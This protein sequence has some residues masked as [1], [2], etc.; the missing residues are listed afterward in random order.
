MT[1]TSSNSSVASVSSS[2]VVTA[3][4]VGNATITVRTTDG[5]FTATCA[6]SVVNPVD[7]PEGTYKGSATVLGSSIAIIISIGTQSNGLVAVRLANT[8]AVATSITVSGTSVTIQTTGSY[9]G[10]TFGNITA[11]YSKANNRLSSVKCNGSISSYVSNN[12]SI[13]CTKPTTASYF[14]CDGTTAQLQNTFKRRYM[15]GSW[16]VDTG[17]ADRITSNTTEFVSGTSA[18]KRR[19][20]SGGAVAL[21]FN[22]DFSP[23]LTLAN[24]YFW[25]YNPSSS[26]ITLR[27]WYYRAA[28]FGSNGETG[29]VVAKAN[30]WTYL[31]M[32]FTSG[33]VYNFQIADFTNSGVYLTFDDIY[34]Y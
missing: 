6:F 2:G 16:Q 11:T 13:T 17:N 33:T 7:W 34:L 32:G 21:N 10:K 8:D 22:S 15:S 20:Y 3:N 31:A 12:G 28:N 1:W 25:V 30:G 9:S 23:A 5:G 14:N 4:A 29:S 24:V 27:M 18:V 19:G 26:D